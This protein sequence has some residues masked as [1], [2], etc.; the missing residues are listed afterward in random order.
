[1]KKYR[2]DLYGGTQL[3]SSP[4]QAAELF[5]KLITEE[6]PRFTIWEKQSKSETQ[7]Y[8]KKVKRGKIWILV[9]IPN[10]LRDDLSFVELAYICDLYEIPRPKVLSTFK[11]QLLDI[12][13]E[14]EAIINNYERNKI[15]L[16]HL[17]DF[18]CSFK[19]TKRG[20]VATLSLEES[21]WQYTYNLSKKGLINHFLE[22]T[23]EGREEKEEC[24]TAECEVGEE[25]SK[26]DII[27]KLTISF[28][29]AEAENEELRK[30]NEKLVEE[31]RLLKEELVLSK[32]TT[33]NPP[34]T[35]TLEEFLKSMTPSRGQPTS[36]TSLETLGTGSLDPRSP[37]SRTED[38][39]I[40]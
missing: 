31:A 9:Q 32:I 17:G 19:K 11:N 35:D 33:N 15:L 16:K 18:D 6:W 1:M 28:S 26:D 3:S 22:E 12:L 13:D 8:W 10:K 27:E 38:L 14:N 24:V 7:T 30:H 37:D 34:K 5:S 4:G 25:S 20:L 23:N 40:Y 29:Q 36:E 21:E 39:E 2:C